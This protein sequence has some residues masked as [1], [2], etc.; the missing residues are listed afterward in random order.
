L[1]SLEIP[2]A[3]GEQCWHIGP[4]SREEIL[5]CPDCAGTKFVTLIL[6]TGEEHT[7]DCRGCQSGYDP[8]RGYITKTIRG[9]TPTPFTPAR[10]T[11]FDGERGVQYTEAPPDASCYRTASSVDLFKTREECEIACKARESDF[12]TE[13]EIR[14]RNQLVG[15]RKDLAWSVHYWRD[16]IRRLEGDLEAARNRLDVCKAREQKKAKKGAAHAG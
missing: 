7:L 11:G 8:P 14:I 6:G 16:Q 4:G 13:E 1:A 9:Y 12:Y 15:R 10:V 2:F 3:I 5:P